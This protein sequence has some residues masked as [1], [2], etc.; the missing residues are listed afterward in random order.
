MGHS[1]L[2]CKDTRILIHSLSQF[3]TLAFYQGQQCQRY[4]QMYGQTSATLYLS[5]SYSAFIIILHLLS[6]Y[7]VCESLSLSLF[8]ICF[9][10][11]ICGQVF[12]VY[13]CLL[14]LVSFL[15]PLCSAYMYL[16]IFPSLIWFSVVTYE[17]FLSILVSCPLYP[18]LGLCVHL[19]SSLCVPLPHPR[20]HSPGTLV[21][22]EQ[23]QIH[24]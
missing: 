17:A 19:A 18:F 15:L 16:S 21:V 2:T 4:R 22:K 20:T 23:H 14:L 12:R 13:F 5:L 9:S 8:L 7:H 24:G 6:L 1:T 10:A 3:L 11:F